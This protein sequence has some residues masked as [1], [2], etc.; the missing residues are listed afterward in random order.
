MSTFEELSEQGSL[1]RRSIKF[2][3]AGALLFEIVGLNY[4]YF[5][6]L[7]SLHVSLAIAFFAYSTAVLML[8]RLG[9]DNRNKWDENEQ[10]TPVPWRSIILLVCWAVPF[11]IA[12]LLV[13]STYLVQVVNAHGQ[14]ILNSGINS[15]LGISTMLMSYLVPPAIEAL[16]AHFPDWPLSTLNLQTWQGTAARVAIYALY[17]SLA[18]F[19]F[20]VIRD[21]RSARRIHEIHVHHLRGRIVRPEDEASSYRRLV[22]TLG[23]E[24]A[25]CHQFLNEHN[26]FDTFMEAKTK[27]QQEESETQPVR[28]ALI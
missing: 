25:A 9:A 16:I 28:R 13:A 26:L 21:A 2:V 12:V 1:I 19:G 18:F 6:L 15:F 8:M 23:N 24:V 5:G 14:P 20:A 27:N 7:N 11:R 10:N 22:E 17:P 3:V 4:N